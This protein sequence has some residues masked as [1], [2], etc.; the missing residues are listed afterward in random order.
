MPAEDG[1]GGDEE[2][3][4]PLAGNQLGQRGDD[5]SIRPGEAGPAD[6]TLEHGEL[7][8]ERYDFELQFYA[9]AKPTGEP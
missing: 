6:L 3:R 1:L 4:P 7:V 9:A 8:A 2:R 5:R